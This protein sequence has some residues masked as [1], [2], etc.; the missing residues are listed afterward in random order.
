MST[1][2]VAKTLWRELL[3]LLALDLLP[4][5]QA[6]AQETAGP[7]STQLVRVILRDGSELIGRILTT[8][9]QQIELKALAGFTVAIPRAEIER[10]EKLR[11]ELREGRF[12]QPDPNNTRLFFAPTGRSLPQGEGYFAVYWLFFPT[13]AIGITNWLALSGGYSLLPGAEEQIAFFAPK[14][15]LLHLPSF[16][17]SSGFL[18]LHIPWGDGDSGGGILYGVGSVG[19][20]DRSWTAGLGWGFS[21]GKLADKP[22]LM[23]G[24]ELRTGRRTKLLSENYLFWEEETTSLLSLGIRFF[25]AHLA[26]DF[27]LFTSGELISREEGFPF[28]PWVD[29]AYSF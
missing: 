9:E 10:V 8:G 28:F 12:L 26:A 11:G 4:T 1:K 2:M 27:G 25:G 5:D 18:Y 14:V 20:A 29:F 7:D 13:I 24:G 15:R 17:L 16:D 6:R 23:F 19:N 21:G 3:L 22:V